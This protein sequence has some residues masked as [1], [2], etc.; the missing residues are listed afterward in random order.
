MGLGND[1]GDRVGVRTHDGTVM[2]VSQSARV[3]LGFT[4]ALLLSDAG[5][6]AAETSGNS[7]VS[8]AARI[9]ERSP[10]L[11]WSERRVL[12]AYLDGRARFPARRSII[13]RANEAA[14]NISDVD[15]TGKGCS[16][17]FGRRVVTLGG[18]EAQAL[19]ATLI[20]AGVPSSGAAGSIYESVKSLVCTIDPAE[21]RQ[22]AGGGAKCVFAANQ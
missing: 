7:A 9:G 1:A 2:G 18:R 22:E 14:C 6:V 21:V 19:Y 15:I 17:T 20:E 11:N 3:I 13:V 12:A 8:L 16:L 4:A 10:F 5:V